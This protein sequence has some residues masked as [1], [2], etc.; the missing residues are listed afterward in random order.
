MKK[1]LIAASI[2]LLSSCAPMP[3]NELF[4]GFTKPAEL[5]DVDIT[6]TVGFTETQI[7]CTKLLW[8]ENRKVF[9]LN[10]AL[11]FCIVPACAGVWDTDG[12]GVADLCKTYV[13]WDV[14]SLQEHEDRHCMGYDDVLY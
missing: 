8:A 11:N 12:D 3:G 14:G 10:C 2:L 7:E 9:F 1:I 4:P 13:S 6:R 5:K